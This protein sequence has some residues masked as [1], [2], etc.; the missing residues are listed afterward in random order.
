[1][2]L[3]SIIIIAIIPKQAPLLVL[4][5]LLIIIILMRRRRR[6]F[7]LNSVMIIMHTLVENIQLTLWMLRSATYKIWIFPNGLWMSSKSESRIIL[8]HVLKASHYHLATKKNW[9]SNDCAFKILLAFL[10][11]KFWILSNIL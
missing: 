4:L 2:L 11:A 6:I 7:R 5:L 8:M 3:H 9:T 10:H 1:M